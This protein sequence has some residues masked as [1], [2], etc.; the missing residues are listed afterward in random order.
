[1]RLKK[2]EID[3]IKSAINKYDNNAKVFLFGSRVDDSKKGGD[4]DLLI[5][6]DKIKLDEK[7]KIE[8][9]LDLLID[10]QKIDLITTPE[11]NSAFL[12]NIYKQSIQL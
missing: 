7:L 11:L 9:S 1:M 5:I 4:I 12:K 2:S 3:A 8:T 10:E 6:S